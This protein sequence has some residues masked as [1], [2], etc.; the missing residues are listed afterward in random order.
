L[1][2][3]LLSEIGRG[4]ELVFEK[5]NPFEIIKFKADNQNKEIPPDHFSSFISATGVASR[6]GQV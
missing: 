3:D 5:F 2:G 4:T 1:E 6:F